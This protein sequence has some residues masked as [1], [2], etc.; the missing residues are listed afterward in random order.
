MGTRGWRVLPLLAAMS[1]ALTAC[2]A[3]AGLGVDVRRHLL[4]A[5][6]AGHRAPVAF[7]GSKLLAS[8]AQGPA[9]F[10]EASWARDFVTMS[11]RTTAR[12]S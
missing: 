7:G 3:V 9:T 6:R 2:H 11:A 12:S 10:F 1:L 5:R 4:F 8:T